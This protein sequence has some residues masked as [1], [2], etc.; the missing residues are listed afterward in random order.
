MA[1]DSRAGF[2]TEPWTGGPWGRRAFCRL[3]PNPSP[4]TLE[5]TNT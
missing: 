3:C 4:M 5:G 1:V 2:G